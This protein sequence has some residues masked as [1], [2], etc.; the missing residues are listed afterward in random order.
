VKFFDWFSGI[1]GFRLGLS[2][3]GMECVGSCEIG[4]FQR[5]VYATHFE[6]PA[7]EDMTAIDPHALPDADLWCGGWPCQGLSSAGLRRGIFNDSRSNLIW[8]LLDMADVL[9]R[10]GRGPTWL[11]LENVPGLLSGRDFECEQGGIHGGGPEDPC[12]ACGRPL[13]EAAAGHVP[14]PWFGEL[15]GVMADRGWVGS[16]RVLDA[17]FFG[18]AQHRERV[19]ILARR[20]GAAGPHP[21]AVLLDPPGVRRDPPARR[22]PRAEVAGTVT[23]GT[24]SS[25][26]SHDASGGAAAGH[27]V[28]RPLTASDGGAEGSR[29]NLVARTLCASH[30]RSDDG[31]K[32]TLVTQAFN[33]QP[34]FGQGADLRADRADLAPTVT[35]ELAK[36]HD[37]GIRVVSF[38][39]A[40]VTHPEN[41]SRCD[42]DAPAPALAAQ[43]RPHVA[44]Y[45]I[46]P[47]GHREGE[48]FGGFKSAALSVTPTEVA[49]TID[50][51]AGSTRVAYS[52]FSEGS[53]AKADHA[54]ETDVAR[55]LDRTGG[56][57]SGQGGTVVMGSGDVARSITTKEGQRQDPLVE[58]F[59]IPMDLANATRSHGRTGVGTE[60][61]G[62]GEDGAPAYTVRAGAQHG[63]A[64]ALGVRRLTPTECEALMGFPRGWTNIRWRPATKPKGVTDEQASDSKRY[65][66]LGNSVVPQ[67]VEWIGKRLK[68]ATQ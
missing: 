15:V 57:A 3:A 56:F 21:D 67:V 62:I 34:E 29:D 50:R 63:V 60:G 10:A 68:E 66:A 16:W 6:V 18:V 59:V 5:A 44:T 48:G 23:A 13:G 7:F 28:A 1:G 2:R 14:R 52:V 45:A 20:A 33:V 36:T 64:H 22:A 40:Q 31:S 55:T 38:D 65:E 17:Q 43:G 41:R 32:A 27:L 58:T 12:P 19:F 51:A 35:A 46:T 8:R 54:K 26:R 25:R 42:P 37:R 61:T 11:L 9:E 49:P 47:Q 30:D 39:P 4:D 24:G 53:C